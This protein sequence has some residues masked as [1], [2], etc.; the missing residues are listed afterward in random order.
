MNTHNYTESLTNHFSSEFLYD[1]EIV[2]F[3][4]SSEHWLLC[5]VCTLIL[6]GLCYF[7]CARKAIGRGRGD[8]EVGECL[9]ER[10]ASVVQLS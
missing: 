9:Y 10:K 8:V 3:I 1:E 5:P 7:E 6:R 4:V 2:G